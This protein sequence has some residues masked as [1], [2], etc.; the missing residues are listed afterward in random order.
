MGPMLPQTLGGSGYTR[1]ERVRWSKWERRPARFTVVVSVKIHCTN[2]SWDD[3][4]VMLREE[5][6]AGGKRGGL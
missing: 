4:L 2:N 3:D 1:G 6:Q 5:G